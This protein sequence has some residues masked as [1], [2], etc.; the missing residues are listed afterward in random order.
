[1]KRI[2][3]PILGAEDYTMFVYVVVGSVGE[4]SSRQEW[5]VKAFK[6][7]QQARDFGAQWKAMGDDILSHNYHQELIHHPL[8]QLFPSRCGEDDCA[9]RIEAVEVC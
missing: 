1:M 5:C 6:D 3:T 8:D 7:E 4:Y 9:F 2:K